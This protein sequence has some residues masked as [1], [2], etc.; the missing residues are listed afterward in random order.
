MGTINLEYNTERDLYLAYMP[1]LARGGLFIRTP[2][3]YDL[4]VELELSVTLPDS[5]EPSIVKGV[6]C[7]LTPVGTQLGTPPGIGIAFTEDP[8]KLRFQIEKC[9]AHKTNSSE[10]TLTM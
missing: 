1:F 4:N 3:V 10:P 8:D 2:R 7:W 5:L 6:I 9:L